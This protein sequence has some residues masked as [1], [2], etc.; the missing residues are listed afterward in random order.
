MARLKV[1]EQKNFKILVAPKVAFAILRAPF[2]RKGF[3]DST[4]LSAG[5]I[6]DS[7]EV[8]E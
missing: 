1:N 7:D 4:F 3:A 8:R 6:T 5:P 2:P